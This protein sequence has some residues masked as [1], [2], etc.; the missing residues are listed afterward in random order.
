MC[1]MLLNQIDNLAA[2]MPEIIGAFKTVAIGMKG[3]GPLS[4]QIAV[5]PKIKIGGV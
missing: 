3:A 5:F 2:V 4:I 1:G